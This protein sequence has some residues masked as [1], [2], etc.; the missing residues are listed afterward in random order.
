MELSSEMIPVCKMVADYSLPP[1]LIPQMLL[2]PLLTMAGL[3]LFQMALSL[4]IKPFYSFIV[5]VA[6]LLLSTYYLSPVC[7]GNY[8]MPLRSHMILTNGVGLNTGLLVS[9][10]LIAVSVIAG[11]LVFRKRD[12][13]R[14]EG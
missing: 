9:V 8:A 7:I 6:I 1:T 2:L 3:N 13:L 5:T 10:I 4:F 12:I 11:G 14:G